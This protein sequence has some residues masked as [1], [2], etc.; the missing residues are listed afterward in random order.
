MSGKK[1]GGR[2]G[3][4]EEEHENHE[5]WLISYA[6]MIT[7]LM[8]FFI[9]LFSMSVLDATKFKAV[10]ESLSEQLG[11]GPRQVDP[12]SADADNTLPEVAPSGSASPSADQPSEAPDQEE[13]T[14]EEIAAELE[15]A[16]AQAGIGDSVKIEQDPERGVVLLLTDSLLFDVGKAEILPEG[17]K[18]L[19]KL[20]PLIKSRNKDVLVEGH[21]DNTPISTGQFPSNWELSTS[22]ATQ[23]LRFFIAP[24]G[25]APERLT[26]AGYADTHPREGADNATI[27]GRE[28]NRRVEV[29][30]I[31]EPGSGGSEAA[32]VRTTEN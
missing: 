3:H 11:G 8:V 6:D 23:V 31:I 19:A 30:L 24:G 27:A 26:A 17:Q 1:K 10:A 14:L 4:Q 25:I 13:K 9:V 18:I 16:I 12:T 20:T 22:R 28:E 29:I 32:G 5:R 15:Q 21:T 7:L 2:A